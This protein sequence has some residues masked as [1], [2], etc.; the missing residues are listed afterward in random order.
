MSF[1][2]R[3]RDNS[4]KSASVAKERLQIV[5]THQRKQRHA[6]EYLQDLQNDILAVVQKYV[7]IE[8]DLVQVQISQEQ[9]TSVLELNISL[10]N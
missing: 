7:T 9:G 8:P 3:F 2:S 5:V 4:S 1:F 10:P 6:P